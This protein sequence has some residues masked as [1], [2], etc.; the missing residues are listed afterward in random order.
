MIDIHTHI[1]P[2]LDDGAGSLDESIALAEQA[3]QNGIHTVIA[4]PHHHARGYYTSYE[5]IELEAAK[6]NDE[7]DKR[8]IAL[9]VLVGQEVR[10]YD[11]LLQDLEGGLLTT[12]ASTQYMLIEF[13]SSN[14]PKG[15]DE[16]FHELRLL[17]ITPIIAHPERNRELAG[18]LRLLS[19][20]VEAGALAQLT[21]SSVSG[22]MG[23]KLQKLSLEMCKKGLVHFIASDA[24]HAVKRPFDLA[25]GYDAVGKQLG[26]AFVDY[27][28]LNAQ[29]LV[30]SGSISRETPAAKRRL[31]FW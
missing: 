19:E 21:S 26:Q 2:G 13:P 18:N 8:G 22:N 7:L 20:L 17:D 23:R 1:L 11:E 5:Q 9:E 27:Y 4:T 25:Q 24:H 10:V 31:I 14:V 16:L 6:L 15:A 3:V 28:Q 12:L 29:R 30:R